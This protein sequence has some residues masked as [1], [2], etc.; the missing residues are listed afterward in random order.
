[1]KARICPIVKQIWL[2]P[3][4][5]QFKFLFCPGGPGGRYRKLHIYNFLTN[6]SIK[7]LRV[8]TACLSQLLC[9]L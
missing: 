5:L 7:K 9:I 4:V 8:Y 1:M 6:G 2:L 3:I